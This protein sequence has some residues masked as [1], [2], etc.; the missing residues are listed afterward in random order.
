MRQLIRAL[1]GEAEMRTPA[2][3]GLSGAQRMPAYPVSHQELLESIEREFGVVLEHEDVDQGVYIRVP[4][5][6]AHTILAHRDLF[7]RL[8]ARHAYAVLKEGS[9]DDITYGQIGEDTALW[10]LLKLP[11]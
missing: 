3:L 9:I 1:L 8:C 11:G 2:Y 6:G 7:E 4:E 5:D 10:I